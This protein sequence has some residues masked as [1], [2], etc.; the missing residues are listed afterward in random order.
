M[1]EIIKKILKN[2]FSLTFCYTFTV[3]TLL[4][5][6]NNGSIWT[7]GS[8]SKREQERLKRQCL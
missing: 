6:A 8:T 4:L 7:D 3:L 1:F 5:I 2:T